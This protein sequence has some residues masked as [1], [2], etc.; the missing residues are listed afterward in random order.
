MKRKPE[1]IILLKQCS[2]VKNLK[3]K[4]IGRKTKRN[5]LWLNHTYLRA[6]RSP[7]TE[8]GGCSFKTFMHPFIWEQK[9]A[10]IEQ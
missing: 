8:S 6:F 10:T 9:H 3:Y 4:E 2:K 1:R 5:F 7:S